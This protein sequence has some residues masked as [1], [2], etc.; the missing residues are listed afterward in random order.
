MY[1]NIHS[2]CF[3]LTRYILFDS[4]FAFLAFVY[5]HT[6]A[7]DNSFIDFSQF[8]WQLH[9]QILSC[10]LHHMIEFGW[11]YLAIHAPNQIFM[12]RYSFYFGE[13][14]F[15]FLLLPVITVYIAPIWFTYDEMIDYFAWNI[16][17]HT[18]AINQITYAVVVLHNLRE[19]STIII[20]KCGVFE[21]FRFSEPVRCFWSFDCIINCYHWSTLDVD[22]L[23]DWLQHMSKVADFK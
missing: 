6:H 20:F 11:I 16:A 3:P 21:A 4:L 8:D 18:E 22:N 23:R 14:N 17:R 2:H 12:K 1:C 7:R 19:L 10:L 13:R 15:S 5:T 9:V